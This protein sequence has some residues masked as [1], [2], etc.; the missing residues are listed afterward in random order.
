MYSWGTDDPLP[1]YTSAKCNVLEI[2]LQFS[3]YPH[4]YD[5]NGFYVSGGI[6]SYFLLLEY[7]RYTYEPGVDPEEE[8]VPKNWMARNR[9]NHLIGVGH[10][11]LGYQRRIGIKKATTIAIEPFLQ[12]PF[13]GVGWG[14][15]RL[16]NVG[17]EVRLTLG[18]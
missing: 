5:Q 3:Y 15:V 14:E 18:K 17:A 16:F 2:P 7:Y 11:A 12:L 6:S 13:G 4:G 1:L 9:N 10:F 8:G